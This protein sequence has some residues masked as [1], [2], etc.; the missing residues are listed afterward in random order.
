MVPVLYG[1]YWGFYFKC[2]WL[3]ALQAVTMLIIRIGYG[4]NSIFQKKLHLKD[5]QAR[6]LAGFAYVAIGYLPLAIYTGHWWYFL[7]FSITSTMVNYLVVR[8]DPGDVI[9]ELLCG[10]W[11]A[12][13]LFIFQ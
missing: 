9:T 12:L 11:F 13:G 2:W 10:W 7:A 4:P 1:L 3:G 6:A 8:F 5:L